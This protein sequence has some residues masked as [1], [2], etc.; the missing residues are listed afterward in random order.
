MLFGAC[1]GATEAVAIGTPLAIS[2]GKYKAL[3][4]DNRSQRASDVE[5]PPFDL[6]DVAGDNMFR[7]KLS[8]LEVC[9]N[10]LASRY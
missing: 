6:Q 7:G 2:N 8:T 4:A 3:P 10:G 1:L 9:V 5:D